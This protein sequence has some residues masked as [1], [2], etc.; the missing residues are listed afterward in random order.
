M[1]AQRDEHIG[2]GGSAP[3]E[4]A[5]STI[6]L[7]SHPPHRP[8]NTYV[9]S[10]HF[11]L[12]T[13]LARKA[14]AALTARDERHFEVLS[15]RLKYQIA[16]L[17]ERLDVERRRPGSAGESALNRDLEV[18]RLTQ[19]LW[20]L[21]RYGIDLCLGH[22]VR[23]DGSDPIY[24]GRV[25][26]TDGDGNQ[27]L[28][29]WRAPAAEPFFGA[30]HANPMGLASRRRYHW[31]RS[32]VTDYWDEVFA[33]GEAQSNAALDNESSFVA[34]LGNSR[35]ARMRDV[36][37]TIQTDQ[38][39][40]IRAPSRG[41]LVVDGGPGTGKTVV[42]LHR[43]AYL[44]YTEPH[45]GDRRGGVL[46]VGPHDPY[47]AYVA[48]VLPSLG[49]DGVK[50]C[51]V[52]GLLTEGARAG[53]EPDAG[54]ARLKAS[55]LMKQTIDAAVA[56][57]EQAPTD[58]LIVETTWS[59]VWLSAKDWHEAFNSPEPS[60]PH[61][62]ARDQVWEAL[63]HVIWD[64]R[65]DLTGDEDPAEIAAGVSQLR[66]TMAHEHALT[67]AFNSAWPLLEAEDVVSDLWSVPAYLRMC[68]PWLSASKVASL[69]RADSQAWTQSD[70][71]LLD[72]ARYRLGD[73]KASSRKRRKAAAEATDREY[74]SLVIDEASTADKD[75]EAA[76]G[77]L[78]GIDAEN[79]LARDTDGPTTRADRLAGPF[80]HIIVDEAQEL[81]DAQWQMLLRRCPSKSFTIVG[82]RAQA[83]H[84]FTDTWQG[85]LAQ[86]GIEDAH[87]ATLSVNYRTP[88]E[89]MVEAEPVIREAIPDANVPRSVRS[90]GIPVAHG[91]I[92]DLESILD[93][94]LA[95]H[96]DGTACVIGD[97]EFVASRTFADGRVRALTPTL[98]KG[99]E[100]DLVVLM[101]PESFGNGIEGAVDRYVAMTRAT[102]EL[103]LLTR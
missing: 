68:A 3:S 40:I 91:E 77:M 54:V 70:V 42:A 87:I 28:I 61:N 53:D 20:V 49:E 46:F 29:D 71:P 36:L 59:E 81:T 65:E 1:R 12:P 76:V 62:E 90:S 8:E 33:R 26:L 14:D 51:T 99:L 23:D 24:I 101:D 94:W 37:A 95:S 60:T 13:Q 16:D 69:Q 15:R 2:H 5:G 100:F 48:D 22:M 102:Q 89:V 75:F 73:A 25:G 93:A 44:L 55:G 41:A 56:L 92:T 39:A 86:V 19:R 27:L 43:A 9:T 4:A 7:I 79:T 72:A 57:Y 50:T 10:P 85:R 96:D 67:D 11:N 63:V 38:D 74:M 6:C 18:H 97:A 35:S 88:Q 66:R 31:T 21:R 47:L 58:G 30:T 82:D 98:A 17:T 34:S 78:T 32:Q 52:R 84:G 64:K 83:R 103:V 45:L 80:S